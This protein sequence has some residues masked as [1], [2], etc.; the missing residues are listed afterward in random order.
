MK[1]IFFKRGLRSRSLLG[2]SARVPVR[3]QMNA[4]ECGAACLAMILSYY[5]RKTRVEE[6]REACNPGRD[7]LS[8]RTIANA[9][10]QF[11]LRVRAYTLETESFGYVLL[12]AVVHWKFKH[13]VVVEKWGPKWVDIVDPV[14]GRRRITS[15]EFE[16]GFTGVVLTFERA[17]HLNSARGTRSGAL[18]ARYVKVILGTPGAV[19]A[20][21]QVLIAS[22]LLQGV[23]LMPSLF[24]KVV[25]DYVIPFR[26]SNVVSVLALGMVLVVMAQMTI[27]YLRS[28]LLI[29][30]RGRLDWQ[31]MSSFFEHLLSLP[32]SF[33]QHRTS[34]DLLMR[35]GSNSFIREIIT[36]Q[37][38][39]LLLDGS[40]VLVYLLIFVTLAPGFGAIAF[41][42]GVLQ[43]MV[44]VVT[45][46]RVRHLMQHELAS[47]A[48]EQSYLVEAMSGISILKAAGAE[49]RAFDRWS[50]LFSKQLNVSLERGYLSTRIETAMA[51]VRA[52]SPLILLWYGT[53]HVLNGTMSLG[54]M[55]AINTLAGAFLAPITSLVSNGQQ[56]QMVG[57]QLDRLADVLDA[58]PEQKLS[59][60][61]A[62]GRDGQIEL[63]N[64][65]FRYDPNAPLVL[66]DI[67]LIIGP[68]QKVALVGPTGSGKST[69]ALLLL[70]LYAP[71]EG[72]ILYNGLPLEKFNYHSLRE[73]FGVVLQESF[74][75]SGSIRQNI[76]LNRPNLTLEDT[77]RA[78]NLAGIH[79]NILNMPM[80]YET[81][82]SE[83]GT[84]LS[85]GQR[86]QIAIAR[87]L[88]HEPS[89]LVLDEA[90]SH[91]DVETEAVVYQNLSR[92]TC[93]R[94]VIAHRLSTVRNADQIFVLDAG[95]IIERGSHEE[96]LEKDGHYAALVRTQAG[97]R[98][99]V[100]PRIPS[101]QPRFEDAEVFRK[102][103]ARY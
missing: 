92:L 1:T 77:I 59:E 65:S 9:A 71:T 31:L 61:L 40:F 90:T 13:F 6:C 15:A 52:L 51:T 85:G 42:L 56:L 17:G 81:F 27:T 86:Q 91:L 80:A 4:V 84:T 97:G 70:G 69:L 33:F 78:A 87:A 62:P 39:S 60:G 72:E 19:T 35:L 79:E 98:D 8:A 7:G 67:S 82:V 22:L 57:A 93:T 30:L 83:G 11:G 20:L 25:I 34:G 94:V 49:D 68:A 46:R 88:A 103:A 53:L 50:D 14:Q 24:T 41:G 16:A 96:L 76:A 100:M 21:G 55:L 36:T 32:F 102:F 101:A 99:V 2:G 64:V 28:T 5:G 89:I 95:R 18:L 54:T 3:L 48:D 44:L 63:S 29:Y 43:V 58:E 74:L 45:R 38:L 37:T 10:R 23:G 73:R 47:K 12:P 75:F 26:V 66:R